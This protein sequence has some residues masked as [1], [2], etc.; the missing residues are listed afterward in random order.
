MKSFKELGLSKDL[1]KIL[2]EIGFDEPT[3]IQEKV[4]P[5]ALAGKDV[6]AESA[7]GS[8]KTLAFGAMIV[9]KI[10]SGKNIQSLILTPTRELAE[11]VSENLKLY[12]KYG[13]LKVCTIYGG[14]SLEPQ[15]RDLR[16]ADVVVGT[17]GRILDHL[18]RR[19][20]DL[21]KVKILILDEAD[22][23]LDMGFIHDVT[24]IT[25][26][27]P[28]NRQTLLF[29]ATISKD[30]DRIAKDYMIKPVD[31]SAEAYVDQSKLKQV[32]YDIETNEKLSLLIHLL[33]EE[34]S[35]L[36][37]VFCNTKRTTDFVGN[38]LER[39]GFDSL[40]LHGDL[41]QNQRKRVLE[42]FHSSSKFILVCTDVAAR[43]LDIKNVSH[44][45]NYDTPKTSEEYIHRIG[46][47]AR[48]GKN[49]KAITL[50]CNKDY[51]NFGRVNDNPNLKIERI[52]SPKFERVFAKA[53]EQRE[54][55]GR[56]FRGRSH[57]RN[58]S[59]G[60][61]RSFGSRKF[62]S[63]RQSNRNNRNREGDREH[64]QYRRKTN[65]PRNFGGRRFG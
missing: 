23:M 12:S 5:L 59:R 65:H 51:E 10:K 34:N 32:Y 43:G 46:R 26:Q 63:R 24:K 25:S 40:T 55:S 35:K 15:M 62:G 30:I 61:T 2:D 21:S 1:L 28:K 8:G 36:V 37:M 19:T 54:R 60:D 11:Q 38:N 44:V 17:P 41:N 27:C 49:G 53:P 13:H 3:E 39:Y 6:I 16:T 33:K 7:T 22:R 9:E 45:Y 4:I 56:N 31:V 52:E 48:A 20:I 64:G 42:H 18:S 58:Y 57:N 29:S 50:L 14:V 47:T